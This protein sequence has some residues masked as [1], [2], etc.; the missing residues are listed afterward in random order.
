MSTPMWT[1]AALAPDAYAAVRR[2]TIFRHG[3]W[4]PQFEDV[5]V[6]CDF[7]I[8]LGRNEWQRVAGWAEQLAAETLAAE[9]ELI[10]RPEL[11][12]RLGLPR[13]VRGV[14]R[15]AGAQPPCE[16][17]R[18]MR[19]DFHLTACGWRISEVNS[20]VPGGFIEA[21]GF[22]REMAACYPSLDVTGDPADAYAEAWA[23]RLDPGAL[24]VLVHATAYTDDRQVMVYLAGQLERRGLRA[25]LISPADLCWDAGRANV[26]TA[27]CTG[28]ATAVLRF[29]PAE[30]LPNLPRRCGWKSFF[31]GSRVPLSNPGTALLTQS[32]RFPLVWP[33]L[34]TPLPTWQMLLPETVAPDRQPGAALDGWVF[35]PA[36]GRVGEDVAIRGVTG[37]NDWKRIRRSIRWHAGEWI[38]QRRFEAVPVNGPHGPVFPQLG[39]FTVDGAAAGVYGRLAR[40]PLIDCWSQDVAVL[41]E[42][43]FV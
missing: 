3:K 20:D 31:Q 12:A 23:R 39:V 11:H 28:A 26:R 24:V 41:L 32:K 15:T 42:S 9:H 2:A 18:V 37:E 30:W 6:L 13:A 38:A 16:G 1:V 40:R 19:F 10:S 7:P 21:S 22:T 8:V 34:K 35:K 27:W 43:Q 36:L 29:F 5:S 14:L 33:Q 25:C 17:P 4:D